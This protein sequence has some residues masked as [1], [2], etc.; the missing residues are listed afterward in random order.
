MRY[1]QYK[2]PLD[3]LSRI[4][5]EGALFHAFNDSKFFEIV[6]NRIEWSDGFKFGLKI[7]R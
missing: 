7:K 1:K 3:S 6:L 5:D 4:M 2:G